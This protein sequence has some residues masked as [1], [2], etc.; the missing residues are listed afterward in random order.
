MKEDREKNRNKEVKKAKENEKEL[1]KLLSF[2]K[3]SVQ[4]TIIKTKKELSHMNY[5]TIGHN[6]ARKTVNFS[7]KISKSL[8][9]PKF[10][11]ISQFINGFLV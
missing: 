6:F 9:K 4:K 2:D 10:M 5:T 11:M 8:T 3:M 7:K 1:K